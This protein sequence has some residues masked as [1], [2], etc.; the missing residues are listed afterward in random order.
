MIL[1][2]DF[3]L[4]FDYN[5]S[6]YFFKIILKI[7]ITSDRQND[8]HCDITKVCYTQ[9]FIIPYIIFLITNDPIIIG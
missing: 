9:F 3:Q 7:K 4:V 6:H 1:N 8:R 2:L 5:L